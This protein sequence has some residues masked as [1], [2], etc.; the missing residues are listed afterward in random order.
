MTSTTLNFRA[1][2]QG[3]RALAIV[4]VVLA[5]AGIPGLAGGFVGVDVF[6]VLSGYL[7][8]GLLLR[9]LQATGKVRLLGFLARR[10]RRLLPALLVMLS[11]VMLMAALLLSPYEFAEQT[12]SA[13]YA[14][15]WTSN[16]YFA[17][18]TFDYFAELRLRDVFLHTWSLGVEEQ[19]YIAWAL[20]FGLVLSPMAR[21]S[22]MQRHR[23]QL[24]WLLAALFAGSL[25][26][27]LYWS[28][29][30]TLHA[31]Y[32]MPARVWQFALGA[33]VFVV[34]D[35][36]PRRDSAGGG[37]VS[38]RFHAL[39][40][41][42]GLLLI[43]GSAVTIDPDMVYPGHLALLPSLGAALAIA[44]GCAARRHG[45]GGLLALPPLRWIGDR[46]Y[47]W[48][49][50]HWPLLML[51][52]AWGLEGDPLP[53]GGL[54]ALS[55]LIAAASYRYV[56]LPFWRGAYSAFTPKATIAA[57]LLAILVVASALVGTNLAF[58]DSEAAGYQLAKDAR[59]DLPRLPGQ[60]DCDTWYQDAT[61]RPCV[62]ETADAEHTAVL[63]GDSIGAQWISA[64]REIFAAL[65][66]RVVLLTKSACAIVDEDYYYAPAGGIY[67]VCTQWRDAAL[68]RLA[69]WRPDLVLVGSSATYAFSG[70]QWVAGTRRVLDRLSNV[71]DHVAIIPGT[72]MLSF[73]G[74]GCLERWLADTD[75]EARPARALA[76]CEPLGDQ[77]A[78]RV[79]EYLAEA[80]Q[81]YANV[82]LLDLNELVCPGGYCAAGTTGGIAV[83]RDQQHL[84]DTF[85]RSLIADIRKRL[86]SSFP[87]AVA[88]D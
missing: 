45:V 3:L 68:A 35:D 10:L 81:D 66:W 38:G 84:T 67:E 7:I 60:S 39:A 2:L 33:M 43:V 17:L 69:E 55:F 50:W 4:L 62:W 61:V 13:G 5:H 12:A 34:V 30:Q 54:V 24:L 40:G 52:F 16:L 57:A 42:L 18:S 1:D 86:Q 71:A 11:I 20:L 8:S 82:G 44:S 58:Q 72:P 70:E 87:E 22:G 19:F 76:C 80:V 25:A 28:A 74:P 46:S 83:F 64:V 56:E 32:L 15:T 51:G 37:R 21:Y 26:L 63:F 48:Y 47:S 85:V 23:R 59:N 9:E 53:V 79:A 31:F 36:L 27:S 75:D 29:T 49:L 73:D 88:A 14:A 77:P 78:E 6:F 65:G 41:A